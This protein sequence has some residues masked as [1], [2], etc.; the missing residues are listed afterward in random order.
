M[1]SGTCDHCARVALECMVILGRRACTACRA[2]KQSCEVRGERIN[3]VHTRGGSGNTSLAEGSQRPARRRVVEESVNE[4]VEDASEDVGGLVG[5]AIDQ[6]NARLGRLEA[7]CE[8]EHRRQVKVETLLRKVAWNTAKLM[9]VHAG[10][11]GDI[12][13]LNSE[14]ELEWEEDDGEMEG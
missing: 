12:I 11:V 3:R 14:R 1:G 10:E 9:E 7:R 13:V 5:V 2:R 8:Q 6:L 4:T